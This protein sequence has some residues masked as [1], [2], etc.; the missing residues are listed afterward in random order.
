MELCRRAVTFMSLVCQARQ[1]KMMTPLAPPNASPHSI[2]PPK[3]A[4]SGLLI[5]YSIIP[6]HFW[7]SLC[8]LSFIFQLGARKVLRWLCGAGHRNARGSDLLCRHRKCSQPWP[9]V[10][11][12]VFW[13]LSSAISLSNIQV[14]ETLS[15]CR[16]MYLSAKLFRRIN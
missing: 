7:A 13:S 10:G 12:S 3:Y 2:T 11:F 16:P 8:F 15:A 1:G 14:A 4:S 5:I 6:P 9:L